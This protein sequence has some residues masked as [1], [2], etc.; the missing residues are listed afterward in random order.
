MFY[1]FILW[2]LGIASILYFGIY[3]VIIG[4]NNTFTYFW[5]LLGLFLVAFGVILRLCYFGKLHL[6]KVITGIFIIC[7]ILFLVV[8]SFAE[9]LI[10]K[11]CCSETREKCGLYRD[12]GCESKWNSSYIKFKISS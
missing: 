11:K 1:S 12:S 10:I 8:F 2:I 9:V 5:L 4:L 3:A 7:V 6:P